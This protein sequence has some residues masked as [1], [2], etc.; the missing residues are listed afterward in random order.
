MLIVC[1]PSQCDES[2]PPCRA[3]VALDIPCTFDRP[4][5]RRGPPNRHAEAMKRRKVESQTEAA[6]TSPNNVA[7]TLASL[8]H[9][10]LNAES[11]CPIST[12]E[13]LVDD[14]FTYIHPLAPFPHEPSF[15]AAFSCREDLKNPSFLALL[16]SMVGALV[17]S[18]PRRPRLHLKAQHREHL[19]PSSL[20][21]VE[22]CH[23]VAVEARGAGYLDKELSIYD[24]V[25]SY[26]L[27]LAAAY[28]FQYRQCRLYLGEALNIT[29]SI[30]SYKVREPGPS[31]MGNQSASF[32]GV[33]SGY[34]TQAQPIDYIQQEIGKRVFWIILIGIRYYNSCVT[35]SL[36]DNIQIT[37]TA[38]SID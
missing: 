2:G 34:N 4:S 25:T 19:F 26:F 12:L 15:R 28:T 16:A 38:R 23:K 31:D 9:A 37:P 5:R 13:L 14:F 3:C 17:A 1:I 10:V 24:A 8:S 20:S 36:T 22:R 21:L 7:A 30:D 11:I 35:Y 18:F 6:P 29:R 33:D 27:G 32:T